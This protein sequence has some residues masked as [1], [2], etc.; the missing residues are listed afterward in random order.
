MR[1]LSPLACTAGTLVAGDG[2]TRVVIEPDEALHIA[3]PI[4]QQGDNT[5]RDTDL[6]IEASLALELCHFPLW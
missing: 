2:L 4:S 5:D 1:D 3:Q 6:A